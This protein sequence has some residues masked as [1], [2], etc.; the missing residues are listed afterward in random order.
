MKRVLVTGAT[1]GLGRNAVQALLGK[2]VQVR[3]SGRNLEIGAELAASGAQFVALDLTVATPDQMA[4]LVVGVDAVW[5]C[6]ALSAPWGRLADF[7]AINVEACTRL[8]DAAGQAGVARFIHISTSAIYFDYRHRREVDE[9]FR[10]GRYANAYAA[11]KA[12]AELRVHD[13]VRLYPTMVSVILR[14]R[15]MFGPHDRALIAPLERTLDLRGGRLP[16]P[17]GGRVTLDLTYVDNVVHAMWLSTLKSAL[18]SGSVFNITNHEPVL[19]RDLLQMLFADALQRPLS[20]SRRPYW[21]MAAAAR[22][23]QLRARAGG[24]EPALTAY[25]VGALG[26]DTTLDNMKA[27]YLLGYVPPVSLAEGVRLTAEWMRG[28]R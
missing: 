15:A 27:K 8:L 21:L 22:W 12:A 24:K 1:G 23:A 14:P 18:P 2:G 26:F 3:A 16:L 10:P 20:I 28:Y 11:S 19:L 6:A 17:R 25:G 7:T 4:A 13:A 9:G 5:H